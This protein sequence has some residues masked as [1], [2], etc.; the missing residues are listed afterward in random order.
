MKKGIKLFAFCSI[1]FVNLTYAQEKVTLDAKINITFALPVHND[2]SQKYSFG[3]GG[4]FGA[5]IYI[6][7]IKSFIV[8]QAGFVLMPRGVGNDDTYRE[9][10]SYISLGTEVM[11]Q[12]VS[13][14]NYKLLPFIGIDFRKV[15][16]R[17]LVANGTIIIYTDGSSDLD[18]DKQPPIF[19]KSAPAF[20]FGLENQFGRYCFR[21]SYDLFVTEVTSDLQYSYDAIDNQIFNTP[22]QSLNL[23][24]VKF[25]FG[26]YF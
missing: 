8:P 9:N 6:P 7:K 21:L 13:S 17:Y 1:L 25:G 19:I 15:K 2:L 24:T 5:L 22:T 20:S 3:A 14:N 10:L 11:Y 12:L 23:S 16:D 26:V 18:Y 4:S